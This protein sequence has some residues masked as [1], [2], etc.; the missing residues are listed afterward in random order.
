MYLI[1][2]AR[3]LDAIKPLSDLLFDGGLEIE[4]PAFAQVGDGTMSE[5][6]AR[7]EQD[8]VLAE[9]KKKLSR[10]NAF[11]VYYGTGSDAWFDSNFDELRRLPG[12]GRED[13]VRAVYLGPP[14]TSRKQLFK[15]REA[16]ILK[17]LGDLQTLL[18]AVPP[19]NGAS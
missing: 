11:L 15:T 4:L 14:E 3:D 1:C 16:L 17:D 5:E 12:L 19:G 7:A 8:R 2:D 6:Q 10:C 13:A 18:D 9:H